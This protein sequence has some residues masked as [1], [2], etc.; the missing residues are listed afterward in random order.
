MDPPPAKRLCRT[1]TVGGEHRAP[2]AG[3]P[4]PP[5]TR[6][7]IRARAGGGESRET[8]TAAST[9]G[10]ARCPPARRRRTGIVHGALA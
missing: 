9:S 2:R 3:N 6:M 8:Q 7:Q 4:M 5:G 1:L 10:V